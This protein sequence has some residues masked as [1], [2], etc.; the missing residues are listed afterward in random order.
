MSQAPTT[1]R[2]GR[3][4]REPHRSYSVD[5][6]PMVAAALAPGLHIVSTPIGNLGD[7]TLRALAT[8]AAADL[9]AC[10]DTR[11]TRKLLDRYAIAV[12][13]TPYHDHNAATAR[14]K[15]LQK[16]AEGAAIALVSDA[17]TPLISDPGYKLVR[18]AQE[19]GHTVTAIPGASS[20]LAALT[21]SGL[22]SDQFFFAG[23]LPPKQAA[24]RARIAEL[25]RMPA[26]LILFETGPRIAETMT[27]L[28]AAFGQREAA[29]CRELTKLHEEIR[30]GPLATLARES[31][32]QET[33]GEF[34]LVIA[35]PP[36]AAPPGEDDTDALLRA[37]LARTSLKDAVGEVAV[38]TGLS[39]R[40]L[41]QRALALAE[42]KTQEGE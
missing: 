12:S 27:D 41:Y 33:R 9:I 32:E 4:D 10:E 15:L 14:P 20:T 39:R 11:V 24:R 42:E 30:R 28:A 5:G 1:S 31:A 38:A 22:P 16:L 6:H 23:F 13:L 26:T 17:G 7:I 36:A 19:A 37:A 21:V 40:T 35:P 8:L 25:E 18:A 29:V 34:V 2:S 3:S